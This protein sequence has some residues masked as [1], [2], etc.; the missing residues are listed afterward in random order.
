[1]PGKIKALLQLVPLVKP[2]AALFL[3]WPTLG[4][5][6]IAAEGTPHTGLLAIFTLGVFLAHSAARLINYLAD[7]RTETTVVSAPEKSPA[8]DALPVNEIAICC[9]SLWLGVFVLV[10]LTNSLTIMLLLVAA[11]VAGIYPFIK[12]YTNLSPLLPAIAFSFAIPMAF[13]AQR[14]ELPPA[15]WLLFLA[16][17]LWAM[18]CDIQYAMKTRAE[19]L[20]NGIKSAAV[21]LGDADRMII[22]ALQGMCLLAMFLAGQRFELG[23]YY[24]VALGITMALFLYQQH[25]IIGRQAAA[26]SRAF[27]Y[28]NWVGPIIFSGIVL[29]YHFI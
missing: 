20:K 26:C 10:L 4:A 27:K 22:G 25:L 29:H 19:D 5:L 3:L 18:A 9:G 21:M 24:K 23:L 15:L 28:N 11:L 13:S 17:L 2:C 6:W 14:G 12:R 8:D 16:N 7:R 1:M